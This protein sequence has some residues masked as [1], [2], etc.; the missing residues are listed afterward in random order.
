VPESIAT[1]AVAAALDRGETLGLVLVG[2]EALDADPAVK[3][4]LLVADGAGLFL[5]VTAGGAG[6]RYALPSWP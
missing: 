1:D 4:N 6:T 5:P 3:G 2:R